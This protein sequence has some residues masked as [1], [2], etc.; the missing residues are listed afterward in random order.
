MR[1]SRKSAKKQLECRKIKIEKM[2]ITKKAWYQ[3]NLRNL[4]EKIINE[5]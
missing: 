4:T 3:S 1:C 2:V 5:N